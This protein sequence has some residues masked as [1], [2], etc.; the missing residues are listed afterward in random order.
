MS[1]SWFHMTF[2]PKTPFG[3]RPVAQRAREVRLPVQA[4]E[5]GVRRRRRRRGVR[6]QPGDVRVADVGEVVERRAAGCRLAGRASKNSSGCPAT[7]V[8]FSASQSSVLPLRCVA[9]TRYAAV[10]AGR[11][12]P[13]RARARR[14]RPPAAPCRRAQLGADRRLVGIVDPR[15]ALDLA[16]AGLRVQALGIARARTP[17]PACPRGS[18]GTAAPRPRGGGA[19]RRAPRCSARRARRSTG[20]PASATSTAASPARRTLSARSSAEKPR[21][22]VRPWRS[23]SPS[24]T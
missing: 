21:S 2:A 3:V 8:A 14:R 13:A 23:V 22:P 9:Q 4:A 18:R 19:R 24:S 10:T 15:E 5:R 20:C 12:R 17:R 1:A 16:R 11:A 7:P 6:E